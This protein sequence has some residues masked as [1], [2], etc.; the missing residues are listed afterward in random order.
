MDIVLLDRQFLGKDPVHKLPCNL[1]KSSSG[2]GR[3][4]KPS[5]SF[6]AAEVSKIFKQKFLNHLL[7]GAALFYLHIM[8]SFTHLVYWLIS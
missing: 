5:P 8:L 2:T 1:G 4:K 3:Q 6:G 7:T